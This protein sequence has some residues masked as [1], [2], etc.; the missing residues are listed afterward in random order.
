MS[1]QAALAMK[2]LHTHGLCHGGMYCLSITFKST[3]EIN[4]FADFRPS[5]ILVKLNNLN[6][7]AE[8]ELLSLLG[9]P[10]RA[11]VRTESGEDLPA[12]SPQ[13]LTLPADTSRLGD[14]YLTEKICS[15]DLGETFSILTPLEDLGMPENYL[16]PE[17]LLEQENAVGPACDIWA[18][19]CTL[20]EIRQQIPLFYMIYDIDELLA[21][22][23]RLFG[24]PPQAWWNKWEARK[25]FFDDQ[26]KWLR[27]GDDAQ[28]WSLE[29][30]TK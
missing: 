21:D 3:L 26:G 13:Y 24:K 29:V 17:V 25:D 4:K 16:P 28:E 9:H 22:M 19:G 7:L 23:V 14:K 27:G 10:E 30:A 12:S 11:Y 8:H 15:I 6:Q 20:F 2:W 18:L 1:Y 5:N